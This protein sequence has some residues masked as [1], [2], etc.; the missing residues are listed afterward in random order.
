MMTQVT[1]GGMR[2]NMVVSDLD[3]D[4]IPGPTSE[5]SPIPTGASGVSELGNMK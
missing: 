3:S 1:C 5:V 4:S 2:P